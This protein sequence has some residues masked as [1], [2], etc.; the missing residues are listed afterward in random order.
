M[1][2]YYL[3]P[4]PIAISF[5]TSNLFGHVYGLARGRR[6]FGPQQLFVSQLSQVI[7]Y[8]FCNM[9]PP[10]NEV[11]SKMIFLQASVCPQ[12]GVCAAD[13]PS[14]RYPFGQTP[15]LGRHPY[16][17][18]TPLGDT[19]PDRYPPNEMDTEASGTHPIGMHSC[20]HYMVE[21][22]RTLVAFCQ[23]AIIGHNLWIIR[24]MLIYI[25]FSGCHVSD[26][27]G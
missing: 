4:E 26:F 8:G 10:T 3:L 11:C 27:L 22:I 21:A 19:S 23:P 12:G 25:C 16:Q 13:T 2:I 1:Q 6:L 5:P 9:L 15:P 7:I 17:A 24:N 18:D 14:D 20:L